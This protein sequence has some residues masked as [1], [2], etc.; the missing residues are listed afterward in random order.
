[1]GRPTIFYQV[2]Q[3]D[4]IKGPDIEEHATEASDEEEHATDAS[5]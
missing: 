5:R 2:N 4:L 3:I 1:M